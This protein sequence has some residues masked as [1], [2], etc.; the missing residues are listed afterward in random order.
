MIRERQEEVGEP[1]ERP[2]LGVRWSSMRARRRLE[3]ARFWQARG[4]LDDA[5]AH[6]YRAGHVL[7]GRP[8]TVLAADVAYT[9]AQIECGRARYRRSAEHFE[10]AAGILLV[11][12]PGAERD[13]RLAD[14]HIGRA[15]LHRRRG[16]YADAVAALTAARSLVHRH[17]PAIVLL[18]GVIAKEQGRFGEATVRY[19]RLE[20]A[21]LDHSD[22][23]AL[24]HNLAD[25][26]NAQ[27][28]Y[29]VGE[30]HARRAMRLRRSDPRATAVDVAQDVAVLAAAVAGQH[31]YDEARSLFGQALAVCRAA[32]P[33]RRHEIAGHLHNLA[34]IEHDCGRLPAAESL[35]REALAIK[36]DLLGPAHPE[37][38]LLMTTL[39]VLL[40]ELGCK[41]EAANYFRQALAITEPTVPAH[42]T[43]VSG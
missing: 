24:Q 3:H 28:R 36:Q 29:V 5:A 32:Q 16:R 21:R 33:A 27:Y 19:I 35:Y 18:L 15:D 17:D 37:V 43:A 34:G 42:L 23:A 38:A 31:R 10:R 40:R 41:D 20:Q 2:R 39:A 30:E 8:P 22:A 9:T 6:A 14:V 1:V 12:P 11:L 25:L 7:D 4:R 13:R 26:A